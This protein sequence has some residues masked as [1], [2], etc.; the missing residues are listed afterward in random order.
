MF[1]HGCPCTRGMDEVATNEDYWTP[2]LR[3]N[4]E[5]DRRRRRELLGEHGAPFVFW[6]WEHEDVPARV[7]ALCEHR[8]LTGGD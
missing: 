8:G 6:V 1:W 3:D 5:R 2:K 7:A 4:V